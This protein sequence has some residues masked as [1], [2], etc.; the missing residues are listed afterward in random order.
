[1]RPRRA[2][3]EAEGRAAGPASRLL[4]GHTSSWRDRRGVGKGFPAA[5]ARSGDRARPDDG[6]IPSGEKTPGRLRRLRELTGLPKVLEIVRVELHLGLRA[7]A[8]GRS[9]LWIVAPGRIP[10]PRRV[11][12]PAVP[13]DL[14]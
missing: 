2:R 11:P 14:L 6:K 9:R 12:Q 5:A 7:R 3:S 8:R 10:R 4:R 1:M 13:E